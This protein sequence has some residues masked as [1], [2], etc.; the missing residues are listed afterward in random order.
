MKPTSSGYADVNGIKL[1]HEIHG[2]GEPL[3]QIH[4]GLTTI[5]E[6]QGWAQPL[7]KTWTYGVELVERVRVRVQLV[8]LRCDSSSVG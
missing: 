7:V 5:G 8:R 2:E 6:M 3:V 4:G 1:D